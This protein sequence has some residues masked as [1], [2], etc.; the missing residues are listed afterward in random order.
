M[1]YELV[2]FLYGCIIIFT[3]AF[4]YL[5]YERV[6][7]S[8]GLKS[9]STSGASWQ[10][11][12]IVFFLWVQRTRRSVRFTGESDPLYLK[13][14]LTSS[15]LPPIILFAPDHCVFYHYQHSLPLTLLDIFTTQFSALTK[16]IR[17]QN[18]VNFLCSLM[19]TWIRNW[20]ILAR[21]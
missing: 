2:I 17:Y 5:K 1:Y 14:V 10:Y 15:H 21:T 7:V 19:T 8:Y 13:R 20:Q 12:D 16:K 11:F 6:F 3:A 18:T 4:K 9:S